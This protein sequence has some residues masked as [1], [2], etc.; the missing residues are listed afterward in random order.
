M[1]FRH[2]GERAIGPSTSADFTYS[3]ILQQ[4]NSNKIYEREM[5]LLNVLAIAHLIVL[6][7]YRDSSSLC[8]DDSIDDKPMHPA[9]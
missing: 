8:A 4:A 7:F 6:Y 3:C 2:V 1:C 5:L 9:N